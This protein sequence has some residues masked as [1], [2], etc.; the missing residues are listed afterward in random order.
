M[1]DSKPD[2]EDRVELWEWLAQQHMNVDPERA[3]AARYVAERWQFG[4]W[5]KH[6]KV[7]AILQAEKSPYLH[8]M[9]LLTDDFVEAFGVPEEEQLRKH[10]LGVISPL[11]PVNREQCDHRYGSGKQ[12][13]RDAI[14][15]TGRCGDHGGSWISDSERAEMVQ[16]ISGR[17]VDLSDRA[18]AVMADL[19]DNARSEKVRGDMAIAILDR[20]GVGPMTRVELDVTPA[21]ERVA[22]EL[23]SRIYEMQARAAQDAAAAQAQHVESEVLEITPGDDPD[24]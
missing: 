22:A 8:G 4:S 6:S 12:C 24:A 13:T 16:K 10:R 23:K 21:S 11:V 3:E 18:V 9:R 14:P 2:H 15:G 7:L 1:P 20:I 19:M 17:L 5:Y